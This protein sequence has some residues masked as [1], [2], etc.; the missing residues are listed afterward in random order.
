MALFEEALAFRESAGEIKSLRIAKWCVARCLRSL[1]QIEQ[2]LSG[3]RALL[4]EQDVEGSSDGFTH[5]EIGECLLLMGQDQEAQPH[6]LQA[7]NVLSLDAW[8]ADNEP[9]RIARLKRLTGQQI[10]QEGS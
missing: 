7:Y 3:Q 6:F 2:A 1:G 9:D 8:L 4:A 5:E 10:T